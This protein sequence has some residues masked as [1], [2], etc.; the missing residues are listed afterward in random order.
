LMRRGLPVQWRH[1]QVAPA[2]N[3]AAAAS[4]EQGA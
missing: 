3:A 4:A 2:P 1:A